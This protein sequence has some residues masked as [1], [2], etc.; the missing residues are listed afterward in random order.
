VRPLVG[1]VF[2]FDSAPEILAF[3]LDHF[4]VGHKGVTSTAGLTSMVEQ[5][6]QANKPAP[7]IAMDSASLQ[8]SKIPGFDRV[9]VM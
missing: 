7:R 5:L 2:A 3:T 4:K 9:R 6:L 1:E 8:I